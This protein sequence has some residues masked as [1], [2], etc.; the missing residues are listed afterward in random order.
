MSAD[1]ANVFRGN[2]DAFTD[3]QVIDTSTP[4][5]GSA[6]TGANLGLSSLR[7]PTGGS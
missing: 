1:L 7:C 5:Y 3:G 2:G 6:K 4:R